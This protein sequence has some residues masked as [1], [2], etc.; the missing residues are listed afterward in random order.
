MSFF[1]CV[2]KVLVQLVQLV[3]FVK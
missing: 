1:M 2:E 3:Q